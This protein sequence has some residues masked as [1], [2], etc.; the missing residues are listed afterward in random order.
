MKTKAVSGRKLS[1]LF[2]L[3]YMVSYLTRTNYG[4]II[5]EMVSAT[6]FSKAALSV[7]LTGSFITY[8]AGQII[9]GILG[10]RIQPKKLVTLGLLVTVAM[11]IVVPFCTA[12]WQMAL[13]WSV[14][15]FAQAFMWPPIVKLMVS[16]LNEKEYRQG[17]VLVSFGGSIGTIL[18]FL[19]S[20]AVISIGGWKWVFWGAAACGVLMILAWNVWCPELPK[21]AITVQKQE[22][23]S[24][25]FRLTPLL[26]MI[27]VAI[28]LQGALRDGVTTWTPSYISEIYHLGNGTAILSSVI[29]PLFGML[30]HAVASWLYSRFHGNPI[31]CGGVMF[32]AGTAAAFLLYF[33][34]GKFAVPSLLSIAMLAGC[35]HGV[36][37][38]LISMVPRFYRNTGR[39]SFVSG[40]LNAYTYV[41]SAAST[42]GIALLTEQV[43]WKPTILVWA[44]IALCG[45]ALCLGA[46]PA[47]KRKMIHSA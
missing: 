23:A 28:V 46:V 40:L 43:G 8:G 45:T 33:L 5:V 44:V 38:M 25:G 1:I 12:P 37:L 2:M 17:S 30:C 36:N 32:G 39:V 47:W 27:M 10:D 18:I 19:L 31:L 4:G 22:T 21:A 3:T 13:L 24:D 15:G 7:A 6:G 26:L 16:L 35:M 34:T 41:G 9:V 29:L 11:N 42:Y 20:P 14:N